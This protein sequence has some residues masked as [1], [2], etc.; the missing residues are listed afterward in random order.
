MNITDPIARQCALR[1][2]A[3]AIIENGDETTYGQLLQ[4]M[5][6]T[7]GRLRDAGVQRRQHVALDLEYST[8]TIVVLLAL[9]RLG[10]GVSFMRSTWS[11]RDKSSLMAR[12]EVAFVIHAAVPGWSAPDPSLPA[13]TSLLLDDVA[14]EAHAAPASHSGLAEVSHDAGD[15]ICLIN[16]TSGTTGLKKS[17]A[18]THAEF[19]VRLGLDQKLW[20]AESQRVFLSLSLETSAAK[21]TIVRTLGTGQALVFGSRQGRGSFFEIIEHDRPTRILTSTGM[22]PLLIEHGRRNPAQALLR[23]LT[24][25]PITVTGSELP[26]AQ[27]Q[28]MLAHLGPHVEVQLGSTEASQ[29]GFVDAQTLLAD[30]SISSIL[31]PWVAMEALD[32]N[33]QVLPAG[34]EGALRVRSPSLARGYYRDPEATAQSFRGG[35]FHPGDIGS[36]DAAGRVR[37]SGRAS[38]LINM[39]GS[40]INPLLIERVLN[41]LPAVLE[42]AVI[43]ARRDDTA[44]P[45]LTAVVV[46][47]MQAD[48]EQLTQ[49]IRHACAAEL[50]A[51]CVPAAVAFAAALP[52]NAG[53]K[54]MTEELE[55]LVAGMLG[56]RHV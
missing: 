46:P 53:G 18:L 10:A 48:K 19:F 50:G 2:D 41:G 54:V 5:A 37:M 51:H 40:K 29:T 22:I 15:D 47:R 36:V 27:L 24:T 42:S 33:G 6:A 28:W 31:L 38:S 34:E 12:H 55:R 44:R 39:G 9:W 45:V 30:P 25:A 8:A 52:R 43:L 32:D 11:G 56:S 7:M 17:V 21:T 35:W 4:R 49:Q 13:F 3:V 26:L 16:T 1:P 14:A 23:A 20:L